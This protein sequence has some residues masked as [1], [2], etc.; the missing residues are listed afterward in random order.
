MPKLEPEDFLA[1]K[2]EPITQVVRSHFR[3]Q[4]EA[5]RDSAGRRLVQ[6]SVNP[7]WQDQQAQ[8]AYLKGLSDA[9]EQFAEIAIEDIQED[10]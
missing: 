10:E 8:A 6:M 3:K 9:Y 5:V 4:A 2:A 7:G 1:W